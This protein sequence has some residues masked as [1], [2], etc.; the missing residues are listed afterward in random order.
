MHLSLDT[1]YICKE[2]FFLMDKNI[3]IVTFFTIVSQWIMLCT[4][5]ASYTHLT[6]GGENTFPFLRYV[7]ENKATFL[8]LKMYGG[9]SDLL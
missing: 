7:S 5:N 9:W 2:K 4:L 8:H 3:Q 1:D 6:T